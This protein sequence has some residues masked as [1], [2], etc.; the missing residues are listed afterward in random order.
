MATS[1]STSATSA[2]GRFARQKTILLTSYRRDGTPVGTPVHVAVDG[3]RAF[4]RTWDATWK[5]KRMRN[6]PEVEIA[7][8]TVRGRPTGPAIHAHARLLSGDEATYA[9]RALA[10]KYPILHGILI[11]LVHRLRGYRTAHIEL[12]PRDRAPAHS[13]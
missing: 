11:P 2:L 7:P 1:T 6:N 8:S 9:A 12:T 4:I 5:Y 13:R 3:D 10:R